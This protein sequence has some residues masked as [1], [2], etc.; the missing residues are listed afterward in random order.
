[1]IKWLAVVFLCAQVVYGQFDKEKAVGPCINGKC[2]EGH[3]CHDEEC[4]PNV[5]NDDPMDEMYDSDVKARTSIGPCVNDLCPAGYNCVDNKCYKSAKRSASQPI[6]P[7]I[8]N[9][10]PTGY[11]CNQS[12]YKCY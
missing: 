4:Y 7:C 12:D 10:C 9:L 6:G 3:V 5:Q 8:N 1:M 2:P 11:T